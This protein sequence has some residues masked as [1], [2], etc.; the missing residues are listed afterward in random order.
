MWGLK[1]QQSL[2]LFINVANHKKVNAQPHVFLK[3][4]GGI[5]IPSSD[6]NNASCVEVIWQGLKVFEL[7]DVDTTMISDSTMKGLKRTI[8]KYDKLLSYASLV[9]AYIEGN[10]PSTDKDSQ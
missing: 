2:F 3:S 7:H 4:H 6:G 5:P 8:G 10:Y 1:N 9:M